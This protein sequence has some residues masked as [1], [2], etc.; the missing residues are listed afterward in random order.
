MEV[1][2]TPVHLHTAP[3]VMVQSV[4]DAE[5]LAVEIFEC[6]ELLKRNHIGIF[7][8]G[9]ELGSMG[10]G[11]VLEG[12]QAL[13]VGLPVGVVEKLVFVDVAHLDYWSL[14]KL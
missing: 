6:I 3:S 2:T 8:G 7:E 12:L 13:L 14:V 5:L 1:V 4:S 11:Q 10:S 9:L